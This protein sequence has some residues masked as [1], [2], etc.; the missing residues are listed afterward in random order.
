[1]AARIARAERMEEDVR[2][3]IDGSGPLLARVE[4]TSEDIRDANGMDKAAWC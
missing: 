2:S 1:M 4:D 3:T